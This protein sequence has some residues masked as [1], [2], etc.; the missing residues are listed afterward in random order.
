MDSL[1][2]EIGDAVCEGGFLD[3]LLWIR[4]SYPNIRVTRDGFD[5]AAENGH[6]QIIKYLR[7][8]FREE[9]EVV[10]INGVE[11][12][13]EFLS[14]HQLCQ[15]FQEEEEEGDLIM[16]CKLEA[17]SDLLEEDEKLPLVSDNPIIGRELS[18]EMVVLDELGCPTLLTD[19]IH[20][21]NQNN[22][23]SNQI[24]N[25]EEEE[26]DEENE[27]VNQVYNYPNDT[28]QSNEV[29]QQ[30]QIDILQNE[31]E[32]SFEEDVS[33]YF[34]LSRWATS[35][36]SDSIDL[37]SQ[38]GHLEVVKYLHYNP[39]PTPSIITTNENES[40]IASSIDISEFLFE[41]EQLATVQAMDFAAKNGHLEV[42]KFLHENRT[43]GCSQRAIDLAAQYGHFKVVKWLLENRMEGFSHASLDWAAGNGHLQILQFL[44][45]FSSSTIER[46][47]PLITDAAFELACGNG[48]IH[49]LNYLEE[50]F[51]ELGFGDVSANTISTSL[52]TDGIDSASRHG[53]LLAVQW[54]HSSSYKE[55]NQEE[56]EEFDQEDKEEGEEKEEVK[57]GEELS[58]ERGCTREAQ[59]WSARN[60]HLDTLIWLRNNRNEGLSNNALTWSVMD[61]QYAILQYFIQEEKIVKWT[62]VKHYSRLYGLD[63]M[64]EWAEWE[65]KRATPI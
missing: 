50:H 23:N 26:E 38:N 37:A 18:E 49:I 29:D 59:D 48:H 42:I 43:E 60:G 61:Q 24:L 17:A 6:L 11:E 31:I 47:N 40:E 9:E 19:I 56:E 44:V 63:H 3:I 14:S 1:P 13:E 25:E 30:H 4:S 65:E 34:P 27:L 7:G 8:G 39:P 46:P 51:P 53:H 10:V 28:P 20:I 2:D 32:H 15:S 22:N 55:Y 12:F 54:V 16:H 62:A 33:N 57:V 36:T 41:E 35:G 45:S 58:I 21:S 64:L 52:P 5:K